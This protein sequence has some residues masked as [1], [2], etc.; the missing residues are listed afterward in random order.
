SD[1]DEAIAKD[2]AH[3][4]ARRFRGYA[5]L[6]LGNF[7][8]GW[9][10]LEHR[11]NAP[12]FIEQS[13]RPDIDPVLF[14]LKIPHEALRGR[15]VLVVAEQG[16]GDEIMFAGL[17]GDL[18]RDA[19]HVVLECDPRLCDLF[20]RSFPNVEII[21]RTSPP[22]WSPNDFDVLL[23]AASLGRLYRRSQRDFP[24]RA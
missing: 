10:D 22:E 24:D 5:N 18:A 23:P 15:R 21:A 12:G 9:E 19:N 6:V 14:A 13:G 17:I 1:F 7:S 16:I 20:T 2:P 4:N 8:A 11:W 3:A